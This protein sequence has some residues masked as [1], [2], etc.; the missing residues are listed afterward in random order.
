MSERPGSRTRW[1]AWLPALALFYTCV[2]VVLGTQD[3]LLRP[4]YGWSGP[5]FAWVG[6]RFTQWIV[7]TGWTPL[8]TWLGGRYRLDREPRSRNWAIHVAALVVTVPLIFASDVI[9]L[10]LLTLA[11]SRRSFADKVFENFR[12]PPRL[13]G[14]WLLM[15][16][17]TWL[18]VLTIS[19]AWRYRKE[20]QQREL[21]AS[22]LQAELAEAQL[23]ALKSQL[24]P[25]FLFNSL[26]AV[27]ALAT[28]DPANARRVVLLLSGLLRRAMADAETQEVPLAQEV[29][30]VRS[31]LEIEQI[32]FSNRLSVET[33]VDPRLERARVPHLVL[34]PLVENA[35]RHGI[36]P[37]EGPGTI[38]IEA[39]RVAAGL[40]L[41]VI[42]D[43]VGRSRASRSEGAGVGLANVRA[44][45]ARLYGDNARLECG[46]RA[47]GGFIATV[48]LPMRNT[49][50]PIGVQAGARMEA[51]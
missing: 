24:Q 11:G 28:T 3:Y 47:E 7:W 43:G 15:A 45:L 17:L 49:D 34:Q 50:D 9:L 29:E 46:E 40:R 22:R 13:L 31:Y 8:V 41:A 19:Y 25:H 36:G 14:G 23:H 35:V 10:E 5:W 2:A 48:V 16:A 18:M 26:N 30:F 37:K 21:E 32:R 1:F 42:D 38:R 12:L 4:R 39:A 44:R 33:C 51:L 27:S 20:N 6:N